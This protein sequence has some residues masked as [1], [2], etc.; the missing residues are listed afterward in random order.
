MP[1]VKNPHELHLHQKTDDVSEPHL[2]ERIIDMLLRSRYAELVGRTM[3]TRL[4]YILEIASLHTKGDLLEQQ[5]LGRSTVLRIE[6]WMEFHRL[7]FRRP[8]ESLD[9]V[10]CG[11]AFRGRVVKV[12][13]VRYS[14]TGMRNAGGKTTKRSNFMTSERVLQPNA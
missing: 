6:K 14:R 3:S 9:S 5:G 8:D 2:P 7:R 13:A 12:A 11:F 1:I 10:I 4:D